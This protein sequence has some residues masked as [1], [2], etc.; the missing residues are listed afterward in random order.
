MCKSS[1]F[2]CMMICIPTKTMTTP[3]QYNMLSFFILH[4]LFMES[5]C[6]VWSD[7][8]NWFSRQKQTKLAQ[9]ENQLLENILRKL[10]QELVVCNVTVLAHRIL[11]FIF[12]S[13]LHSSV[14]YFIVIDSWISTM[15]YHMKEHQSWMVMV[16]SKFA[17]LIHFL[18]VII[19]L[20]GNKH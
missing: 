15:E 14:T 17:L 13:L 16:L 2:G 7:Q 20:E 18:W 12:I 9:D 4:V 5:S 3:N 8:M 1:I 6:L 19:S 11:W 10:L